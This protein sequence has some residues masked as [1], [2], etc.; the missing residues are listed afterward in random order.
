M[1]GPLLESSAGGTR[2]TSLAPTRSELSKESVWL[3]ALAVAGTALKIPLGIWFKP[4]FHSELGYQFLS[5]CCQIAL[6]CTVPLALRL[7]AELGLPGAPFIAAKLARERPPGR[8]RSLIKIALLYD[9]VSIGASTLA[10]MG[11]KLSGVIGSSV[12]KAR[13]PLGSPLSLHTNPF[14]ALVPHAGRFAAMGAMAAI[15]AGLSEEIMFRLSLFAISAWLF[16][17]LLQDRTDRPSGTVLW[18]ATILQA[19][20]FGLAHLM[21]RSSVLPKI[22]AP[23]LIVG[24]AAPQTWDGI[25]LGRL[26][27]RHGLEAA[28]IAHAMI[29]LVLFLSAAV[30]LYLLYLS[31]LSTRTR[32]FQLAPLL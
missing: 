25:I 23:M 9:L 8:L 20:A 27:L 12:S 14:A 10:I 6:V 5:I 2:P 31:G 30:L 11:L 15:G 4:L 3:I 24:L 18:C 26:Y 28:V 17:F 7:N 21:L 32:E 1:T 13:M 16:R 22:R 29:D 19:Y